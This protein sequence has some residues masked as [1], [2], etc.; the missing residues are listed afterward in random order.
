MK[1]C[2]V[3]E[4]GLHEVVFVRVRRQRLPLRLDLLRLA[5][6]PLLHLPP[7]FRLL[8]FAVQVTT[9]VVNMRK[10]TT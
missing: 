7:L 10:D 8:V 1:A 6:L 4:Y 3:V 9:L 2:L 5:L